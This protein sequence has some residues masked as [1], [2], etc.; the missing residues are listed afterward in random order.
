MA[1]H[2]Q[3]QARMGSTREGHSASRPAAWQQASP[4][5]RERRARHGLSLAQHTTR[6]DTTAYNRTTDTPQARSSQRN[7][8]GLGQQYNGM[9]CHKATG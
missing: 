1:I 7:H 2:T 3:P 5:A 8:M 4:G 6:Q 9:R